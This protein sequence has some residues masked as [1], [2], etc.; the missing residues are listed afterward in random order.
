[1]AWCKVYMAA[2]KS[3]D[4][5]IAM[6]VDADACTSTVANDPIGVDGIVGIM[7]HRYRLLAQRQMHW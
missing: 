6:H 2:A 1:M 5:A 3:S 4:G 7:Q